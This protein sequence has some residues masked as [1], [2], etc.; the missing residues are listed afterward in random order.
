MLNKKSPSFKLKDKDGKIHDLSKIIS[1]FVVIYFYPKD[2]TPG[3]TIEAQDFSKNLAEFRKFKTEVFGISGGDEKSKS[4]FCEKNEHSVT[5]LSDSDFK[6]ST[7]FGVYDKKKFMGKEYLGIS[8][9]TFILDKNKKIIK[10][11][12]NV[13]PLGHSKE[14]LEFIKS[15]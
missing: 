11:F 2:N 4:K 1:E 15:Q 8:R 12:E 3:C 5:L 13:R 14:V 6:V 7:A 9:T 10:V